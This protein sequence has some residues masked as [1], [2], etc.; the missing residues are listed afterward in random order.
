M[1]REWE[2]DMQGPARWY[3]DKCGGDL[4]YAISNL[5]RASKVHKANPPVTLDLN[6]YT[7]VVALTTSAKYDIDYGYNYVVK[8]SFTDSSGEC[9]VL[10]FNKETLVPVKF[11][12]KIY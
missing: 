1:A 8:E 11:L 7:N 2:V 5:I 3:L 10:L 4:D 12:R 6:P 9:R